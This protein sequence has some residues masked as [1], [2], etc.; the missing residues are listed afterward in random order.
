M[1][2]TESIIQRIMNPKDYK[3]SGY[4]SSSVKYRYIQYLLEEKWKDIC[5]EN[6]Y[7]NC[8]VDK[9]DSKKGVLII[10]TKSS[11]WAS[12]LFMMKSVF[13]QKINDFLAGKLVIKDLKFHSCA[14]MEDYESGEK[15]GEE[16]TRK[17]EKNGHC[18]KCG[19]K[20][21][22]DRKICGACERTAKEELKA[23][24]SELLK[25]EPWLSY[26][27]CL[28]YHKC[29]K[30]FFASVK[31]QIQGRYFEKVRLGDATETDCGMAVMFLT[32]KKPDEIDEKTYQNALKYLR[33]D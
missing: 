27:E 24:I 10:K 4:I 31:E 20:I 5:G 19:A 32:G 18:Q 12:N 28:S 17:E 26:E 25:I 14:N 8:R 9:L 29:E 15:K 1:E 3:S 16:T 21:R 6:L 23:K 33:R 13:L 7:K 2:Q 22:G 30:V 11:A